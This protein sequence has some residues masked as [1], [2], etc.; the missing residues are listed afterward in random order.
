MQD[1]VDGNLMWTSTRNRIGAIFGVLVVFAVGYACVTKLAAREL[2]IA[3][4]EVVATDTRDHVRA[5]LGEPVGRGR[6]HVHGGF[7]FGPTEG[8]SSILQP[9]TPYEQWQWFDER[10]TYYVWFAPTGQEPPQE[11]LVVAKGNHP[12]GAVF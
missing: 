12:T 1:L 9:G 2:H 11:W 10:N 7:M 4:K 3:F 8:L 5:L 6:S